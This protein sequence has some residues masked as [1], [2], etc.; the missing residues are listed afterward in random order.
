MACA[1]KAL[2]TVAVVKLT[3]KKLSNKHIILFDLRLLTN[4]SLRSYQEIEIP[5]KFPV[6]PQTGLELNG[7]ADSQW[8]ANLDFFPI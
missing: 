7:K 3:K 2:C 6:L 8:F 5:N 1:S 4:G